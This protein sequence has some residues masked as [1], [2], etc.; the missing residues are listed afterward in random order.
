MTTNQ[1]AGY[2]VSFVPRSTT[3]IDNCVARLAASGAAAVRTD[4]LWPQWQPTNSGSATV[5][6]NDTL[7]S[8]VTNY[9]D[10]YCQKLHDAGIRLVAM[11]G[12]TPGWARP[13]ITTNQFG[14]PD[15]ILPT[16]SLTGNTADTTYSP[17]YANFCW[18]VTNRLET[19]WP[20][21]LLAIE[22]WNEPN[23]RPFFGC[24][25]SLAL[26]NVGG[27]NQPNDSPDPRRYAEMVHGAYRAIKTGVVAGRANRASYPAVNVIA[28]GSAAGASAFSPQNGTFDSAH[29]NR[30]WFDWTGPNDFDGIAWHPYHWGDPISLDVVWNHA[31]KM[32]V[33][34]W[35]LLVEYGRT[36][37]K[38]WSTEWGVP[39]RRADSGTGQNGGYKL[40]KGGWDTVP[41]AGHPGEYRTSKEAMTYTEAAA[42]ITAW[43]DWYRGPDCYSTLINDYF[44]GPSFYFKMCDGLTGIGTEW[45]R[46]PYDPYFEY[47]GAYERG[48]TE[49]TGPVKT[50]VA[51]AVEAGFVPD[52]TPPTA[53]LA[54]PTDGTTIP[55]G[56][57]LVDV[58]VGATDDRAVK[59]VS[60]WVD[61]AALGFVPR[62]TTNGWHFARFD[63]GSYPPGDHII[64]ALV[65]DVADNFTWTAIH[66]FTVVATAAGSG[67]T[68]AGYGL[69]GYGLSAFAGTSTGAAQPSAETFP[70][71]VVEYNEHGPRDRAEPRWHPFN[72]CVRAI[73]ITRGRSEDADEWDPGTCQITFRN[74]HREFDP[75]YAAGEHY[76]YLTPNRRI[77][78]LAVFGP[79]V[80]PLFDGYADSWEQIPGDQ[81]NNYAECVLT[82]TDLFKLLAR[83]KMEASAALILDDPIEGLLDVGRLGGRFVFDEELASDRAITI[84]E[85]TGFDENLAYVEQ[86][87]TRLVADTPDRAGNVLDYLRRIE[88][89][90]G[91]DLL[92]DAAG[93]LQM[94]DRWHWSAEP[95]QATPT[96]VWSDQAGQLPFRTVDLLPSDLRTVRN[97]VERGREDGVLFAARSRPSISRYGPAE[98]TRDDILTADENEIISQ[99]E[100]ILARNIDPRPRVSSMVILPRRDPARLFPQVLGREL[101]DRF[102]LERSLAGVGPAMVNE[103]QITRIEHTIGPLEWE[104][105]WSGQLAE[106]TDLFRL[107]VTALDSATP[108]AY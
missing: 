56:S 94:W 29:F 83:T 52:T 19:N 104:T 3:D 108:L 10:Y 9:Y 36:D 88:A 70:R 27:P 101:L 93:T 105:V 100:A 66:T 14:D 13:G 38:F 86:T 97:I 39:T 59:H 43:Y 57:G 87:T 58:L 98:D 6:L 73:S 15:K 53:L 50:A 85:S 44:T 30:L 71:I 32:V 91:G 8:D 18:L 89:S 78:V 51:A 16:R 107:D 5:G 47:F 48:A 68:A 82:A 72:G 37:A 76:G 81:A 41:P 45:T 63:L 11:C 42:E 103:Y 69:S 67:Q 40:N 96:G 7:G 26:Y 20:G 34:G 24:P 1:I 2:C 106:S 90:T 92:V 12:Y 55:A 54:T 22:I 61:G 46:A 84:L 33:K 4:M 64:A 17:D 77:R 60:L 28:G 95:D 99:C 79:T 35:P 80:Y 74:D 62:I 31:R 65:V 102:T 49:W 21:L 23:L 75:T 25:S